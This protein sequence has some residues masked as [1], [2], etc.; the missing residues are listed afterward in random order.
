MC[1][2]PLVLITND[3]GIDKPGINVLAEHLAEVAEVLVAAP[4]QERSAVGHGLTLT[5]PVRVR[6]RGAGR[7]AVSGT[8]AD[9][10]LLALTRICPR[11]PS[12]VLSGI[13]HGVNLGTDVFYSGTL[14]GALEGAIRGVQAV[15]VSQD[16]PAGD[17]GPS[18]AELLPRT[19]RFAAA[20]AAGLLRD[21]LPPR[22]VLSV[23]AP[24]SL[25]E[26]YC[27]TALG[28]RVYREKVEQRVDPRGRPYY[29]IGGP[30]MRNVSPPGTDA[31]AVEAGTIS[32]TPLGLDLSSELP[33][34]DRRYPV[35]GFGLVEPG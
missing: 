22:T 29:W 6:Q 24:A 13:N 17:G 10:V 12:L 35:D 20:L 11:R 15:A 9:A 28:R 33:G 4:S 32:V 27:W 19:A 18:M 30:A 25:G 3:D 5:R 31:H 8:P 1:E 34:A 7:Y 23:N 26:R 14:A 21:P 16:L 2:K